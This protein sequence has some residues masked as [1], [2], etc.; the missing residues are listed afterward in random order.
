MKRT[1][2]ILW[3]FVFF[4]SCA[5]IVIPTGGTKDTI[6]PKVTAEHPE[7]RSLFFHEKTI[8]I[9]FDEYV[10]L[11]NPVENII[12]SP[13][14]SQNPEY[15]LSGKSLII[16]LKDT[17]I[18]DKTYNI[19]FTDAIKDFHEGNILTFYQYAFATGASIDSFM[20][21]GKL[22]NAETLESEVGVYVFLYEND[23]DSLPL[24]VRPTYLTK[25][26][27]G[28]TFT[29]QHIANKAYK[30]FALK[31]INSNL[32]FDLPNEG[33]AFLDTLLASYPIPIK[34]TA[35]KQADTL[36]ENLIDTLEKSQIDTLRKNQA[37]MVAKNQLK[38]YYFLEEDTI[39]RMEKPKNPQRNLYKLIYKRPVHSFTATQISPRKTID[40]FEVW[41]KQKDTVTWYFKTDIPDSLIFELRADE[42]QIDT[43]LFKPFK[44]SATQGGGRGRRAVSVPKLNVTHTH[45][46]SLFVPLTLHFSFPIHRVDTFPVTVISAKKNGAD[47]M[48]Y[49]FAVSDTFSTS[50]PLYFPLEEKV[51]YTV[52]MK[53]SLFFGFD[54]TTNDSIKINFTA[55]SERDYGNLMMNYKLKNNSVPHIILLLDSRKSIIQQDIIL[56]SK[57]ITYKNLN[58][59]EYK[60]KVIEDL[61]GNG[62][63][64]TGNYRKKRQPE[65]ILFFNKSITIR[66]YWDLEEN[67]DI[68]V[69]KSGLY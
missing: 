36:S 65:K 56:T 32:I 52:L 38:L 67:F 6:P 33:I 39:Q 55:K 28:G 11:N 51:P 10:T 29:F 26:Q 20:L 43:V 24:T 5:R 27:K 34:D 63:W 31:D 41:N 62:K 21:E 15:L 54:G 49:Y 40:Y 42:Q 23:N 45:A 19:I 4:G 57:T 53:D 66:G 64:D 14:L 9:T 47:T 16:K 44:P 48:L 22:I 18:A 68:E 61:N 2:L 35:K 12:F 50:L 37:N 1:L 60:I 7:N 13:P 8:R 46:G 30:I 25:T 3:L 69:V 17:L 58:P 59:G